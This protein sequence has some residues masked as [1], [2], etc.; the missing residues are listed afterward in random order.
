MCIV[1]LCLFN[2]VYVYSMVWKAAQYYYNGLVM[3]LNTALNVA[4]ALDS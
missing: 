2:G 1:V 4:V 3:L